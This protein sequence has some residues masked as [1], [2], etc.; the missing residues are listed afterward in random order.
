MPGGRL[1]SYATPEEGIAALDANL[2]NYGKQGV[3]TLAGVIRKWAPPNENDTNAYIAD[4]AAHSG[5]KPEQPIDL[6]NPFVRHVIG[7]AIMLHENGPKAVVGAA[8]QQ[9]DPYAA[10]LG[11]GAPQVAAAPVAPAAPSAA[12]PSVQPSFG[13]QS[14]PTAP[15]EHA[16]DPVRL[17]MHAGSEFASSIA[18]GLRG[19]YDLAT[20]QGL[21][22][23]VSDIGR[24]QQEYTY[25]PKDAA[26]QEVAQQFDSNGNPLN[27]PM[28]AAG[29]GGNVLAE[30]GYPAAGAALAAAPALLGTRLG[31]A[32]VTAPLRLTRD[33]PAPRIEPT[34]DGTPEPQAPQAT[35]QAPAAP[36]A[37]S[38]DAANGVYAQDIPE[39]PGGVPA[40]D[41]A[42]RAQVLQ[43]IGL[44]GD[45]RRSALTGD[46]LAAATDAQTAKV[47]NPAGAA[48][49]AKL[50]AEKQAVT[51]YADDIAQK[52]GGT[53]GNDQQTQYARGQTILA[54]MEALKDWFDSRTQALYQVADERAQGVPT[55]LNG[56]RTALGDDSLMTN[57][58]RINLRTAI[59]AYAKK[60]GI[61]GDD[62][63]VFANAQQAETMR[64]YLNENWSPQASGLIGKLKDALDDDV[65]QAA[66]EDVYAAARQMRALR[67]QTL[68]NPNGIAK[69][70]DADGINRKVPTEQIATTLSRMPVDQLSHIVDTLE[71]AP[72]EIQ[73]QAQAALSEIKAQF[74]NAV[75]S[76]GSSQQGQWAAAKVTKYLNDNAQRM[77]VVFSPEEMQRFGTLNDA[78]HILAKDQGY[79]G[80]AAQG[81]NLIRA[82]VMGVVQHGA[83]TAGAAI[84]GPI[85]AVAGNMVGGR[86]ASKID[87]AASLRAVKK[88]F[89]N[90]SDL[91]PPK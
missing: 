65:T 67:A 66:G 61:L 33:V 85:G 45:V 29:A 68:E 12:P 25:N 42:R 56:F 59:G 32:A 50:Q 4:A 21:D 90:L 11:L 53:I 74:A 7:S 43:D 82:G 70:M 48:M 3:N 37:R 22:K 83:T 44:T 35:M 60:L 75:S 71:N 41:Q 8:P 38:T 76:T 77:Q 31:R 64:K 34:L 19:I 24:I 16:P 10:A 88:R 47:D 26:T 46:S 2:A 55:D 79:P 17:A 91:L 69:L 14:V 78:G 27:W 57:S 9:T 13:A 80:A 84:G 23:A 72:A 73:P 54:P 62:G 40:A 63:S 49:R 87:E 15:G 5:L 28:V 20:G 81:H 30:H 39:A 1:A 52:T 86:L 51:A 58:D 36:V 18:G 89:V 6:S